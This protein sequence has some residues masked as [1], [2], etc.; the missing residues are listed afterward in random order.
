MRW[1]LL[2]SS[3]HSILIQK[4]THSSQ[5]HM[6]HPPGLLAHKVSLSKFKKIEIISN[7]FSNH[8]TMRLGI[9]YRQKKKTV[10]ITN[11]KIHY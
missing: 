5:V 1:I 7:I 4:N 6:E 11:K 3:G 2:T 8:N 9:N 10:K